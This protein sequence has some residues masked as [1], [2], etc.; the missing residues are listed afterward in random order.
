VAPHHGKHICPVWEL[1]LQQQ[2]STAGKQA[3]AKH[4]NV[5]LATQTTGTVTLSANSLNVLP[6]PSAAGVAD[7]Y[8]TQNGACIEAYKV[9]RTC[10]LKAAAGLTT[11]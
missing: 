6:S 4:G 3:D 8:I 2:K 11:S 1:Y 9:L 7:L 10:L 5:T